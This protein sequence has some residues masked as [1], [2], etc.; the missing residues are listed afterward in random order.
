[1]AKGSNKLSAKL[2]QSV[3][4]AG[5]YSD[6]DGLYLRVDA[7]GSKRWVFIFQWR[8]KRREMG[9]KAYPL[10]SL[11]EARELRNSYRKQVAE[12]IDPVGARNALA[13]EQ[14]ESP[15]FGAFAEQM[16]GSIEAGWRSAKHRQQ[17][18]NTLRTYAVSISKISVSD[19]TTDHVL[20]I[21]KPIW[22]EKP[23]TASRVRGRIERVLDTAKAKGLRSGENP[24]R[25]RGHLQVL[26][27]KQSKLARG[28]H[29]AMSCEQ[30]P[31]FIEDLRKR[32]GLA[33]RALE[34]AIATA[35]REGEVLGARWSEIDIGRFVW[36][37]PADRMKAQRAHEVPLNAVA[38]AAMGPVRDPDA[39]IF[40]GAK[41]GRPMSNMAMDMVLRRM[42]K[43]VTVHGFRSTFRD[44][45]GDMTDHPRE[46]VEHALAHN[47]GNAV[48]LA[49]R[50]GNALEK[51][52]RLMEDWAEYLGSGA[53][54]KDNPIA[55]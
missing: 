39:L 24:A 41:E 21:L 10:V 48:E 9:L 11:A 44:W 16:I 1:M 8:G 50:R 54:S 22:T 36:T 31:T 2:V 47:V 55:A 46:V 33:A 42:S 5:L 4:E 18:R 3:R 53:A 30:L 25:W 19:V 29:P 15:L 14:V 17:W 34:F 20:H 52:R 12:G 43:P 7:G 38:I 49:Y 13:A 23:E 40:P 51:R 28:H 35:A 26:L 6:G 45:A 27:P 37:V 32:D